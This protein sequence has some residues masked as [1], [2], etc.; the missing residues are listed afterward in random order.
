[1]YAEIFPDHGVIARFRK[2]HRGD[3]ETLFVEVLRLC[4]AAGLVR[5]GVVVLDV[6]K[7][8][9][10]DPDSRIMKSRKGYLQG[11]NAQAVVTADR[12]ILAA[13]VTNQANDVRQLAR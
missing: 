6:T 5:L 12:I 13:G 2:R 10:S 11:Y 4:Y 9:A 8:K 1:M 7:V 3:L